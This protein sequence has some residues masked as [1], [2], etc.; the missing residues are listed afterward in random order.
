MY[1][2][3]APS[4]VSLKPSDEL[5]EPLLPRGCSG[6]SVPGEP[7]EREYDDAG[8]CLVGWKCVVVCIA[9]VVAPVV[10]PA[11]VVIVFAWEVVLEVLVLFPPA[12]FCANDDDGVVEAA[13]PDGDVTAAF[14]IAVWARNADRKLPKNG[15]LVVGILTFFLFSSTSVLFSFATRRL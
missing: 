7:G 2:F 6:V 8:C 15:L 3:S 13:A 9:T 10:G 11:L 12:P 4:E 1:H 14:W 5:S